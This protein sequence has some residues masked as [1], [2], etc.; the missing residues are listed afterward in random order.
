MAANRLATTIGLISIG[1]GIF[2]SIR[3][4]KLATRVAWKTT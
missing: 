4:N 2:D 1:F 3:A